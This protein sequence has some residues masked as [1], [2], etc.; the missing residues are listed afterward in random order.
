MP[1][2]DN[3]RL[4][5]FWHGDPSRFLKEKW[6]TEN[7]ASDLV[8]IARSNFLVAADSFQHLFERLRAVP[9][10]EGFPRDADRQV[11]VIREEPAADDEVLRRV[12]FKEPR[13]SGSIA[14]P[15]GTRLPKIDLV[16]IRSSR[17][18]TKPVSIGH[19][20]VETPDLG[21]P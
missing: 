2:F 19:R 8:D 17:Q 14:N 10:P 21:H 12:E 13:R 6:L 9:E 11:S 16:E 3:I 5:G 18:L 15:T 7:D 1:S 4:P 20:D